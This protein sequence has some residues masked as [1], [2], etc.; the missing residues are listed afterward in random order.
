MTA[1]SR[2]A[3]DIVRATLNY[4]FSPAAVVAKY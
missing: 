4:R 3:G 2:F 1:D